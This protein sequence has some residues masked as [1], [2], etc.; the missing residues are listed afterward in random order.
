MT[1]KQP[2]HPPKSPR[3][4]PDLA[5]WLSLQFAALNDSLKD[6]LQ[7][8]G[9]STDLSDG[10]ETFNGRQTKREQVV[11]EL[12]IS[13]EQ[14]LSQLRVLLTHRWEPVPPEPGMMQELTRALLI[15]GS[16]ERFELAVKAVIRDYCETQEEIRRYSAARLPQAMRADIVTGFTRVLA[17]CQQDLRLLGVA[18]EEVE[19]GSPLDLSRHRVVEKRTT[20]VRQRLDTVCREL[21]PVFTWKSPSGIDRHHPAQ[22]IAYT[23][24][25]T[26]QPATKKGVSKPERSAADVAASDLFDSAVSSV[27]PDRG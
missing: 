2:I 21:S 5:P 18:V 3:T 22:V 14:V 7:R 10:D 27:V 9:P 1:P 20:S 8:E 4:V 16:G 11:Q 13:L 15:S 26:E 19:P 24:R 17:R 6:G 12:F 25:D 23:K